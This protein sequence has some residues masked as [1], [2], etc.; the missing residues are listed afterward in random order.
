M[1]DYGRRWPFSSLRGVRRA[2]ALELDR[3]EKLLLFQSMTTANALGS[4]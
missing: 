2:V 1:I 4:T 3:R